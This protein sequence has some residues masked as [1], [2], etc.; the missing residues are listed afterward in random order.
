MKNPAIG[1]MDFEGKG[2]CRCP[3]F[4]WKETIGPTAIK[5]LNSSKLWKQY[6]NDIFV[7]DVDCGNIYHFKL[8]QNRTELLLNGS[9][10]NKI[11]Y[12]LQDDKPTI[13]A[14]G[15]DPIVDIQMG[16]DG[17]LY[18]LSLGPGDFENQENK[19]T[20]GGTIY[21]W[22]GRSITKNHFSVYLWLR[23]FII[24]LLLISKNQKII[25]C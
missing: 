4:T 20:H 19:Q 8:N 22:Y 24:S 6:E 7:G 18:V 5:F 11:A 3:E 2:K 17:Y 14:K 21:I 15:L 25:S 23:M 16:P 10:S 12:N 9:L 1:L 13:F